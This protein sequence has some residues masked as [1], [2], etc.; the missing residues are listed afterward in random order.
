M[1]II[2]KIKFEN[3]ID[4]E[5]E[6]CRVH[7]SKIDIFSFCLKITIFRFNNKLYFLNM[8]NKTKQ[9][10]EQKLKKKIIINKKKIEWKNEI[11]WNKVKWK[12]IE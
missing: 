2:R 5:N 7:W 6:K 1:K 8:K 3:E 10:K 4:C 11:N 12:W 9:R